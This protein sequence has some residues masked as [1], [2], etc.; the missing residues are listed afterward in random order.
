MKTVICDLDGTLF[1]VDHRLHYLEKK[2]WDGFFTA[3]KDDTPNEWCVEL[4]KGMA[5][6]GHEVV[7]VTGRNEKVRAETIESIHKCLDW[8]PAYIDEHLFMR[9]EKDRSP[10]Y[11]L[12][13][14]IHAAFL[15]DRDILFVVEDRKQV[16][17]M[18]RSKGYVVLHCEEGEF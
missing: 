2:D 5:E 6:Q 8:S 15:H 10:D 9:H 4:L 17:N 18:W 11:D 7:F 14:A 3:V 13:A 16:V 1:N 12:K